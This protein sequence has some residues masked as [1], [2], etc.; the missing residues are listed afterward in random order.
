MRKLIMYANIGNIDRVV[1]LILGIG[2]I[3]LVVT[4]MIGVW[5]WLGI[6]MILTALIK[7]CPA[8]TILGINTCTKSQHEF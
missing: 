8:Y 2:L 3:I 7:T 6:I 1:R 4:N 5:G